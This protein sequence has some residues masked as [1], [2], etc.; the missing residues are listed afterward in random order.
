M[1]YQITNSNSFLKV[2]KDTFLTNATNQLH[3]QPNDS[4]AKGE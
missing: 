3:L 4:K 2:G 1:E